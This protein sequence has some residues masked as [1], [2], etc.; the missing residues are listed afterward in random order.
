[1]HTL[2]GDAAQLAQ[3]EHL[4][5]ARVGQNGPV[6]VHEIMQVAVRPDNVSARPQH[7]VE[8]VTQQYLRAAFGHLLG[9]HGLD[10]AVGAD[11]HERRRLHHPAF[12][13]Q[14]SA[15]GTPGGIQQFKFHAR[16]QFAQVS[17][18]YEN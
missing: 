13:H 16:T 9:A 5:T 2:L 7:Q 3:A 14:A 6:P 18:S 12:E 15:P 1:M 11:R 10:G 4:K 17:S 8:G